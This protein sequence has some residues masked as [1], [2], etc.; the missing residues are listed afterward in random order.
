AVQG[1]YVEPAT[2]T[3][4]L[5]GDI[6][7]QVLKVEATAISTAANFFELGGHSLLS[8]KLLSLIHA[9]FDKVLE[10]SSLFSAVTIQ[11]QAVL[12]DSLETGLGNIPLLQKMKKLQKVTDAGQAKE[13]I[14][15]IPGVAS[16]ANDF[17]DIVEQLKHNNDEGDADVEIG[18]FRHQGLIAGEQYFDT[19]EENVIAFANSLADLPYKTLTLV[20]HSYGGALA[21]ALAN[22]LKAR[23]YQVR[24]V[25]LDTY[26]E[27]SVQAV[28]LDE[29]DIPAHLKGLYQHQV[30]LFSQ[31][32][33]IM[34][35]GVSTT[36]VFAKQSRVSQSQY[37]DYLVDKSFAK[38]I[39]YAAV[40]GD[41]FSMLTGQSAQLIAGIIGKT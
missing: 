20:G 2:A 16:T 31:Y 18:V 15:L 7:A 36:V 17:T 30:N 3:E 29:L 28:D 11:A 33:P 24:L 35:E 38:Q 27:Q 10:L 9:R 13:G 4:Q 21:M 1:E 5:L 12:L 39:N 32:Q 26:F 14:I 34:D 22:Y 25:M 37:Q 8:V 41:H 6:W 19:I 23:D 40:D